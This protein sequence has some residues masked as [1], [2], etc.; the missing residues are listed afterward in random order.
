LIVVLPL[1]FLGPHLLYRVE[2]YYPRHV[3]IGHMAMAAVALYVAAPRESSTG[4][5]RGRRRMRQD[6]NDR[7]GKHCRASD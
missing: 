3:V 5:E 1:A 2:S 6:T 7:A 4:S